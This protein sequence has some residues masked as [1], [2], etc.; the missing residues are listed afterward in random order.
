M[1][2]YLKIG[3]TDFSKCT[4]Y[5]CGYHKLWASDTGRNL[6]GVN[7]GTLVGI[8]TKLEVTMGLLG[9]EQMKALLSATNK[10]NANVTY[11]DPMTDALKTENF[12]FGD[13]TPEV[14]RLKYEGGSYKPTYGNLSFSIIANSPR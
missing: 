7:K 3:S 9:K 6:A 10:S 2:T 1:T 13:I 11:Y 4:E 8:F 5:T 12:Y 14:K